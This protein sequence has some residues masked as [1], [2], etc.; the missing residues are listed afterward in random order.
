VNA[1]VADDAVTPVPRVPAWRRLT[2]SGL[3]LAALCAAASA[4][5]ADD[6]ESTD[7]QAAGTG[8]HAFLDAL[9]VAYR[10]DADAARACA[11]ASTCACAIARGLP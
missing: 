8:R 4:L 10:G 1:P 6:A 5:P 7:A 11:C 9:A 3:R 2:A